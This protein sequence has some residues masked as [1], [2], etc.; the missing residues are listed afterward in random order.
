MRAEP[1]EKQKNFKRALSLFQ[2]QK[3]RENLET[4]Y[5]SVLQWSKKGE[6]KT[7]SQQQWPRVEFLNLGITDIRVG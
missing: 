2:E 5:I 6:N 3:V 4:N 1:L 7:S